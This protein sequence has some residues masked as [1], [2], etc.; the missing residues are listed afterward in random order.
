MERSG[1]RQQSVYVPDGPEIVVWPALEHLGP[2]CMMR[3]VMREPGDGREAQAYLP[4]DSADHLAE[5]LV[6]PALRRPDSEDAPHA[7]DCGHEWRRAAQTLVWSQLRNRVD[8]DQVVTD[9]WN[10]SRVVEV[11]NLCG[12]PRVSDEWTRDGE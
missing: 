3:M 6:D 9:S 1:I 4:I 2:G 5:L 10:R 7:V 8:G 11:C 12:N